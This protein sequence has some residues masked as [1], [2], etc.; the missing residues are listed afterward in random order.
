LTQLPNHHNRETRVDVSIVYVNWNSV[1]YLRDS[2]ASIYEHTHEIAFEIIIVD[3]ASPTGDVDCLKNEFPD[4]LVFKSS[5]NLGFAGANNLGFGLATG[6]HILFLNPDTR[7]I[8]PAIATMS[9]HLQALPKAGIVGCKLLNRDLSVQTS[10]IQ[11]FPTILNQI[12]DIELLRNRF[13]NVWLWAIGPLFSNATKPVAV[14]VISGACLMIKRDVFETTGRFSEEY[15]MYAEDLDLCYKVTRS[16]YMNYYLGDATLMHY[17]GG[18]SS[19]KSATTMKWKS[20][21]RFCEK[22]H[23]WLY[24]LMFRMAMACAAT[25][26]LS[27]IGL[28]SLFGNSLGGRA[29]RRYLFTKW[30]TVLRTVLTLN[31][32]NQ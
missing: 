16:G 28:M 30:G 23:G 8:S 19:P 11:T 12:L 9:R 6:D 25:L 10:C 5:K 13:P 7:L 24:S 4:I 15:F 27:V 29:A 20:I 3:N 17:G 21:L 2:I 22:W 18:S 32:A 14:E 1:D 31:S 26:R